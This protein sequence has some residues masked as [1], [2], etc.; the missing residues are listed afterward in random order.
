MPGKSA[1]IEVRRAIWDEFRN[2]LIDAFAHDG[3][4][5][6]GGRPAARRLP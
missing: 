4:T 6:F 3:S 5:R 2:R 1:E